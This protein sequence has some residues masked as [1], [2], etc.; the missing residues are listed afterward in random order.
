MR[1]GS[2]RRCSILFRAWPWWPHPSGSPWRLE[3]R[4]RLRRPPYRRWNR[5]RTGHSAA[6][7]RTEPA[8][9]GRSPRYRPTC[10]SLEISMLEAT[11]FKGTGTSS[12][13]GAIALLLLV[14][15]GALPLSAQFA[16]GSIG[17]TVADA[18]GAVVPNATV[19]LTDEATKAKRETKSN[20]AGYFHFASVLPAT[21][22]VTVEVAGF[23]SWEEQHIALTQGLNLNLP[24]I[25]L[26]VSTQKQ[27][28]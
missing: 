5:R 12:V 9:T 7:R 25:S 14:Q 1:N 3:L 28:V 27:E 24:N 22:T 8:I 16:A 11:T 21:Y 18:S 13:S 23:R 19:T 26:Q 4:R 20:S 15:F 2:S 10:P 6:M 17:G